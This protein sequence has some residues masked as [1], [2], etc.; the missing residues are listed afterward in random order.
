MVYCVVRTE[1]F[2]RDGFALHTLTS[3]SVS[4]ES[5]AT[6]LCFQREVPDGTPILV[7]SRASRVLSV[8]RLPDGAMT[9]LPDPVF[10]YG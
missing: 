8:G 6:L 5:A 7:T 1:E 10:G 2:I 3:K 9:L 4:L